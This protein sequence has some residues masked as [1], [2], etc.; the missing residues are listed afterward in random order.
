[1]KDSVGILIALL[2]TG[3]GAFIFIRPEQYLKPN[4]PDTD[5]RR[6][7]IRLFK[8]LGAALFIIGVILLAM[9]LAGV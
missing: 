5:Q 3:M 4:Q 7:K 8:R 1:M 9:R 6:G 2:F